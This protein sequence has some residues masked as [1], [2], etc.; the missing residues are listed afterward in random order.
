MNEKEKEEVLKK[1]NEHI[2][3][4]NYSKETLK[5]Y[6]NHARKYIEFVNYPTL[7]GWA[8]QLKIH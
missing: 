8:S 6:T 3:L 5:A 7:K 2:K 4:K 1:L